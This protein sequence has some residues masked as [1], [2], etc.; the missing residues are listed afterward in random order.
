MET[1]YWICDVCNE[2]ITDVEHGWIQWIKFFSE[3]GVPKMGRSLRLVHHQSYSPHL[4]LCTFNARAE[5]QKDQG[6]V[7]DVA[8]KEFLSA[9]G[10]MK[11]AGNAL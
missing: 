5:S 9:D 3:E 4:I 1:T 8:L 10:L 2:R 6:H 7:T 11:F